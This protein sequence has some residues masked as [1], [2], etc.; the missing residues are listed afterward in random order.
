MHLGLLVARLVI[1]HPV[2]V[3]LER[4]AD[5]GDVSMPED[6]EHAGEERALAAVA[7][8]VLR[9]EEEHQRLRH[10]EA[11]GLVV[12]P[13]HVTALGAPTSG[14]RGSRGNDFQVSLIQA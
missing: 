4:L 13:T 6:A 14:T 2:G 10:G 11:L 8:D 1:P 7:L 9:G 12:S 5:T 3:L